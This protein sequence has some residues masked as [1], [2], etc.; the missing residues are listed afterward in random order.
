MKKTINRKVYDTEK[1]EHVAYRYAGEFGR[2]DGYEERLFVKKNGE[3]F[4]Y[5]IGGHESKYGEPAIMPMTDKQAKEWKK[6]DSVTII[7]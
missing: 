1:A 3:H 4:V 6:D 2:P 7:A 5:G